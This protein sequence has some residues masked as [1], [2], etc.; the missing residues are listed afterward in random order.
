MKALLP[1]IIL[2]GAVCVAVVMSSLRPEPEKTPV[3]NAALAVNTQ[4]IFPSDVSLIVSSQGSVKPRT[5]TMLISEV[6]GTVLEVSDQFV[7]GGRFQ[8]GDVLLRLDPSDY[9]VALERARAQEISKKAMFELEKA[10]SVQAEKEWAMTGRSEEEAPLLALRKPYLAEA[11]AHLLQAQAEVKQAELKLER[12]TI[13]APYAGMVSNKYVD[14]GQY[15]TSGV[16]LGEI[17][18]VDFVEIRLPL[19]EKDLSLMNPLFWQNLGNNNEVTLRGSVNGQQAQWMATLTRSEGV[20]NELTRSQYLVARVS[21]PYNIS[22]DKAFDSPL[23]VGTFVTAT[24]EGKTLKNVMS[25]PRGALLRG[26]KVAVV[27]D[28]QRMSIKSVTLKFSNED[29]YYVSDGLEP[30]AQI[31]VS[32]IGTPVEGLK[33][34][35]SNKSFQGRDK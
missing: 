12:T 7:V 5:S 19:T 35:I 33:L 16:Q 9:E 20:I 8:V 28:S 25:I 29:F 17:F 32:A 31:I 13:R 2:I 1:V 18:A 10:R 6:S 4:T 15:V 23:L 22:N 30:G 14:V 34:E 26:S 27:D 21:D 11:T 3:V 24:F